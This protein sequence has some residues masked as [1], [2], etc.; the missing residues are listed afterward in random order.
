VLMHRRQD[1]LR[2]AFDILQHIIVPETQDEIALRSKINRS[3][4]ISGNV[5]R[6]IVLRSINLDDEAPFMAGEVSEE[7]TDRHLPSEMRVLDRQVTQMPPE[8]ALRVGHVATESAC[9][10]N[11]CIDFFGFLTS[12]HAYP[13]T[14]SP[15]PPLA[16]ARGGG[17]GSGTAVRPYNSIR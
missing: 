5:L 10:R 17:E 9:A 11:A 7:R 1:R 14:P 2:Y 6:L 13:P 4:C 15:S 8:L 3:L 12:S 16:R